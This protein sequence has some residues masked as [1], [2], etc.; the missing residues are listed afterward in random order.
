MAAGLCIDYR[1][2]LIFG[3]P[4]P[5]VATYTAL[6]QPENAAREPNKR[7]VRFADERDETCR[8]APP[9]PVPNLAPVTQQQSREPQASRISPASAT[10][11]LLDVTQSEARVAT[12]EDVCERLTLYA[13][14]DYKVAAESK[15]VIWCEVPQAQQ[16]YRGGLLVEA[17][18][19]TLSELG[20]LATALVAQ[21]VNGRVPVQL[22]NLNAVPTLIA[23][24]R[25]LA[26][27]TAVTEAVQAPSYAA[28]ASTAKAPLSRA[29]KLVKVLDELK[30]STALPGLALEKQ[31]LL[32]L[33]DKHLD[34]FAAND[35]DIGRVQLIEH[36][37]ETGD[38][39]PTRSRARF[40]SPTQ[41]LAIKAEVDKYKQ[42]GIVRPSSSPWAAPVLIVKKK[43]GTNRMCIDYRQLNMVTVPD[44]FPLPNM[45]TL[46]DK[47][48]GSQWFTAFDVLW[49]YHNIK[50]APDSIAKT[51]FI[52]NDE[53][54]EF[55]RMPFGLSN[56]PATFQRMIMTALVGLGEIS[57][58]YLDDIL[59]YAPD[60]PR[61]LLRMGTA[62][63]R[64]KE[65]GLKLKASQ[66]R[67]TSPRDSVPWIHCLG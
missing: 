37:I 64:I 46:F 49:G 48:Q 8:S 36:A 40:Y 55:T 31:S 10:P 18:E 38:A 65:A 35:E 14:H 42:A 34:A 22:L 32:K 3:P 61:L 47:L 56:A 30:F 28:D 43:D 12:G 21:A 33:I 20:L 9:K 67:L 45:K 7:S 44:S 23:K 26:S 19:A 63:E 4:G 50:I 6:G 15:S 27:L 1:R 66:V 29:D 25:R 60:L 59:V 17:D 54:L 58:A 24:G 13:P 62:L 5:G 57:A 11:N 2:A 51:A 16:N 41:R 52:A 39:L 53:L